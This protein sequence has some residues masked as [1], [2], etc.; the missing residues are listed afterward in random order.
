MEVYSGHKL[1]QFDVM[2]LAGGIELRGPGLSTS[3]VQRP[4]DD[5]RRDIPRPL[6]SPSGLVYSLEHSF[7]QGME[8]ME[9]LYTA[10]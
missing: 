10:D 7:Q 3:V 9:F 1:V 8:R 4:L 6:T 2:R 5:L